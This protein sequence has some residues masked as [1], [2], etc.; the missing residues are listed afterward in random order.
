MRGFLMHSSTCTSLRS[1]VMSV[2]SASQIGQTC[3]ECLTACT[4]Q[5]TR[6][7]VCGFGPILASPCLIRFP[8]LSVAEKVVPSSVYFRVKDPFTF[9]SRAAAGIQWVCVLALFALRGR[10][11]ASPTVRWPCWIRI[12]CSTQGLVHQGF[13]CSSLG[14]TDPPFQ[15][16]FDV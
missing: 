5:Q 15:R 7:L 1:K 8:G 9:K 14:R 3:L 12:A 13:R 2:R 4:E 6:C 16:N 10:L 11:F